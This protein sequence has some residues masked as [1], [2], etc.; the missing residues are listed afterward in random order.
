MIVSAM[1]LKDYDITHYCPKLYHVGLTGGILLMTTGDA[2][3][4]SSPAAFHKSAQT[5]VS[6]VA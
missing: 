1:S 5:P 4:M 3:A 2:E 6:F